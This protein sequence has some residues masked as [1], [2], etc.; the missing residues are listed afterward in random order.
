MSSSLSRIED[1][2]TTVVIRSDL[3]A[4]HEAEK[5]LLAEVA[6]CNYSEAATFAIKLAVEEGV[7]NAIKH[8]NRFDACKTV[9]LIYDISKDRAVITITDQG[10]GFDPSAVPDPTADENL[11]K[12]TGR[13][14]ML[15]RAYMDEVVYNCRGN[16]VRMVKRNT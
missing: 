1:L 11:E 8:G 7:N 5:A 14:V 12:P 9:E 3:A 13:G 2:P 4:A 10:A 6:G 15:M 16:Q